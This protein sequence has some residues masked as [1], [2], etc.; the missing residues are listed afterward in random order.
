MTQQSLWK[1]PYEEGITFSNL[2]KWLCCRERARL[3]LVEGLVDKNEFV[4]AI[5]YGSMFH[6]CEEQYREQ[7]KIS[8]PEIRERLVQY[9]LKLKNKWPEAEK[10]I[11][12]W[13]RVCL[14]QFPL[15]I[16]HHEEEDKNRH[17]IYQEEAFCI[18]F[19]LPSGREIKL[20]GKIDGAFLPTINSKSVYLQENKTKGYIDTDSITRQLHGDLQTMVYA[21]A[22]YTLLKQEDSDLQLDGLLYNVIRRPLS[23]G[24]HNIVQRKGRGKAKTG[25][26]TYDQFMQRLGKVIEDNANDFFIRWSVGLTLQDIDTFNQ[27]SLYPILEQLCDWWDSIKDDPFN[28]W[29]H[30]ARVSNGIGTPVIKSVPNT[31]HYQNPFGVFDPVALGMK[32]DYFDYLTGGS[33]RALFKIDTL[34]PELE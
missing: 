7:G 21:N 34:S 10:E 9:S 29:Y 24:P 5:E 18:P 8:L 4:H 13:T 27:R 16:K 28:P 23:K 20:K 3:Y 15:Y 25:A 26:E 14:V 2:S 22:L 19:E 11:D 1:G 33:K 12:H 31:L 32:G 17:Y 6:E 30:R